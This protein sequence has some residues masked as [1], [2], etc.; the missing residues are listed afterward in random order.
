MKNLGPV[1]RRWL[2]EVGLKT[3][4]DLERIG[5]LEAYRLV[6]ACRPGVSLNLLYAIQGAI[7]DVAWNRLPPGMRESLRDRAEEPGSVPPYEDPERDE[8]EE[9]SG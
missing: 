2:G 8:G 9:R 4:E 5:A 3:R 6:R 1:S 7:M